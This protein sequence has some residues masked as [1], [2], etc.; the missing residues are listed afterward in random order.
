MEHIAVAAGSDSTKN[1]KR[2]SIDCGYLSKSAVTDAS[3]DR[4]AGAIILLAL[5]RACCAA[6]GDG[7]GVGLRG[8]FMALYLSCS[9]AGVSREGM[10]RLRMS[11]GIL[12]TSRPLGADRGGGR[13]WA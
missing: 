12:G 7:G 10:S 9:W 5:S 8:L 4:M 11:R 13:F 1:K 6:M 2:D 3:I